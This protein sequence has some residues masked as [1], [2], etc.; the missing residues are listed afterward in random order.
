MR[1]QSRALLPFAFPRDERAGPSDP[2]ALRNKWSFLSCALPVGAAGGAK[3]RVLAAAAI[4]K[5]LKDSPTAFVQ[6]RRERA[7]AIA[8]SRLADARPHPRAP[9]RPRSSR[10]RTRSSRSCR[11]RS[12][13]RSSTT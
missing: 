11:S 8:R 7:R 3:G 12:A 1:C 10:S 2:H 13:A 6:V 5:G 9:R 4:T